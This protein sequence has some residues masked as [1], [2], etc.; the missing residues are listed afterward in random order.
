MFRLAYWHAKRLII[1]PSKAE[2]EIDCMED[3]DKIKKKTDIE[4]HGPK[5]LR[6]FAILPAPP[7]LSFFTS[8]KPCKGFK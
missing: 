1:Y 6:T 8:L 4:H 2:T 3:D 5:P 7:N